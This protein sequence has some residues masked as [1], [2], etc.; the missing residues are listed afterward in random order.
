MVLRLV[1]LAVSTFGE[2]AALGLEVHVWCQRCKQERPVPLNSP[3]LYARVLA[4]S[5]FRCTRTL[6]DG[7]ICNGAGCAAIRPAT[8][9]PGG[10]DDSMANIYC[11]RCVPPWR[12]LQVDPKREPWRVTPGHVLVC[13]GC[14]QRL[15]C[16]RG[17]RFGGRSTRRA[18]SSDGHAP[19]P[20]PAAIR[21]MRSGRL[22]LTFPTSDGTCH[23]SIAPA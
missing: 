22:F 4:G 11:D 5:H 17:S 23:A 12:A 16:G 6:W 14:R 18:R 8:L 20:A 1:P 3:A 13:P 9:L 10:Q 15:R 7:S 19:Y 21:S 2:I